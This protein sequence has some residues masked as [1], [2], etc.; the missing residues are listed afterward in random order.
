[1]VV[2]MLKRSNLHDYQVEFI[3]F[4]SKIKKCGL[5]LDMGLGKT[6]TSLTA[7]SDFLDDF[8]VMKVLVIAP[9]RVS[10]TVWK[11]EAQGWEHL[12]HLN[13]K[14]CTGTA[15]ERVDALNSN[16]DIY[17][18]NRENVQWL[19][20]NVKWQWD[21]VIIDESSSFKNHAAKRFR[22]LKKVLKHVKSIILLTGTPTPKG[23]IDLWP[24]LFLIDSGERLGKNI[25]IYR[26]RFFG[27]DYSGF[28]YVPLEG[29]DEKIKELIKD[30][31]VTM[32]ATGNVERIDL[33]EYID[34][35]PAIRTQYKELEKEFLLSLE[36]GADIE[37]PTAAVLSGKL[38]QMCN[39]AVYDADGKSHQI[40]D[41][42][43]KALKEMMEDN[44]GENFLVAY[45][46]KSDLE[47]LQKAFPNAVTLSRSGKEVVPWNEGKLG[48]LLAHPA[49]AGHGLN[50]QHGGS[51]IIWFGLNWSLELYQQFNARLHRQGQK[52]I[53]R[54]M[55]IVI[56]NGLDEKVLKALASNAKTQDELIEYLK[57]DLKSKN[58]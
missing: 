18:I 5:F 8:F 10:N 44:P 47:R 32:K 9:L 28:N 21:M 52:N 39:G 7:A 29:S 19:V 15:K 4:I 31:C 14:I 48:M 33:Y 22:A 46:Y 30:V 23:L 53:V 6:T 12:K 58:K 43:I 27:Q 49:S 20:E 50:I 54:I 40:H 13:I 42:K 45:N 57:F 2:R 36:G 41:L 37:V 17:V 11:Q 34:M 56:K 51:V 3:E 1:M 38:L 55:H 25:T 35:P 16:A 26:S 24:Q